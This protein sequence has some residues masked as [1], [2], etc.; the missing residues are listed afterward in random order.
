MDEAESKIKTHLRKHKT[1]YACG[2]TGAVVAG[3]SFLVMRDRNSHCISRGIT[4]TAQR[5]TSVLEESNAIQ[6]VIVGNDNTLN[7][8]SFI[9]ANRQGPPSWVVRCKETGEIF[10]SQNAAAN[11]MELPKSEISKHLNGVMDGVRGYHFERICM[12]A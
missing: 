10:T 2:A 5:G 3:I 6:N 4:V 1:F 9:S 8:V 7:A 11:V 12:V